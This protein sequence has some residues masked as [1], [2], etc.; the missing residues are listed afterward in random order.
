MLQSVRNPYWFHGFTFVHAATTVTFLI[1][2]KRRTIFRHN[3]FGNALST[4][5]RPNQRDMF[6]HSEL[7]TGSSQLGI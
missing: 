2:R 5:V 1:N 3:V 7:I 4:A 6:Q